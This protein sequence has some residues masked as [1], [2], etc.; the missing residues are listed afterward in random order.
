MR[1]IF[2]IV[3]ILLICGTISA[4][5]TY[6]QSQFTGQFG[7]SASGVDSN[8]YDRNGNP[9]DTTSVIDASTIPIG[10]SCWKIDRQ[11]GN[12]TEVPVDTLQHD[13]Q[14]TNDTGGPTGH[15]TYLGNLGSPRISHIFFERKDP[16]Q[17]FFLDPYDFTVIEPEDVVYT[18]TKS[19]FTNLT[20]YKQGGSSDG[21][22]RF[23]AY[24]AV[25]ANKRLGFGFNIDYVYGRGKYM[26]QSTA[27]FNGDLFAYY[28]GDKYNMHFSFIND[29][30][31][32]AEN[33]GIVDDRYVTRPLDMAEGGKVY[34]NDEIPT[35]LSQ[36][37]NHNTG[38]HAFLTH[39]YNVGFYRENPD[40][41]DTVNTEVF[42][43]V[44]SFL[45]TLKVDIN[46]RQYISY[47]ETQNQQYF[48]NNYLTDVQRD[49]TEQLAVKNTFGISL[50][51]G[52][53]KW[54]KA[55]LTAFMS[56]EY[57]RFTMTDTIARTPG[58]RIPTDYVE[59]TISVGGQLIKEQGQTLHY[60]VMGEIALVGEDAG[61]FQIQGKG[62]LNFRLFSDTVRLEANAYIK[63]LN[64]IFY[65]RHFHSKHYWWDNDDLSKIM[66]TRLE[67]KLS[68]DRWKTQLKAGVENIKNYTYLD[69][70]S[71]K[72]TETS[73]DKEVTTYKNDV[74][75][76]QNSGNIQVFS[77]A[78]RQDFKLGI[79]HLDNEITYQKSSNQDVLPLPELTLY[80][81]LY[82]KFGL[83]K[84]VLQIEMGADVRYFTQYYAPDYA[85]A[86]GQFYLQ[87]KETRY[88]LG[89][90][91]LLN[92]Y[93]NL[94]LKRTRIFIAM[95]N[96]I[97]GQ[98]EKSYFLAPH[99]PLNPR[100]L[101][102]GLSWNFFD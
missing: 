12:M 97:Q 63:N 68:V 47:D 80:H 5:N 34:A 1:K 56:H 39:R 33:G 9:I 96:L 102:F 90:Y 75:V 61:Q 73:S 11:F 67:G 72:Y 45:H 37:W 81:N 66:R 58:Q 99:Y 87:N 71:V 14:N 13:F 20:Y 98:G 84:K 89:G 59:N 16:E 70:T 92:G 49:K 46:R 54:A 65:Y 64:P 30:L 41:K 24:F 4:Q 43:P 26:N 78:L 83:A 94:H 85:P 69:N 57:R 6:Q 19:P 79:F 32:V 101:K 76:R 95:Y 22:E 91:P 35:N 15:Y 3:T 42:V 53:N 100:L 82:I 44:T 88:K 31:K 23:K 29:N 27:L 25:N 18:N 60:N 48:Q 52:F 7:S 74:A 38:Y 21:E 62:D 86:I 77:A 55:G 10:L 2:F 36:V 28:L 8:L 93:I 50:R 40:A 51:E 17:F